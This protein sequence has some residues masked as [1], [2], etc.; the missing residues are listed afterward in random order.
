MPPILVPFSAKHIATQ[1][2]AIEKVNK[3]KSFFLW[4]AFVC[5]DIRPCKELPVQ[6]EQ[7]KYQNKVW[8]LFKIEDEESLE[9]CQWQQT[10]ATLNRQ[11]FAGFILER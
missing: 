2:L 6:S 3:R 1:I 9:R 4:A 10:F 11:K 5:D 7:L 8:K